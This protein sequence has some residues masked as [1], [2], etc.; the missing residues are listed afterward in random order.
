MFSASAEF[1]DLIYSTFKDYTGETGQIGSLL[2]RRSPQSH[3]VLDV[4][5]GTG[6]HA[7]LL[8]A[9]GFMVDGLDVDPAFVTIA[10]QKYPAGQFFV[11][12]MSDFRLLHRTTWC[13]DFSVLSAIS[14]LL[15]ESEARL[16]RFVIT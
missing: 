12:D 8:A 9:Q 10:R 2:R 16:S 13:C 14:K 6:E 7:R 1:Y 15:V 3:T 4:V 11:A 5:C